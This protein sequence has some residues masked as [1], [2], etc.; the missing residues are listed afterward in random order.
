MAT[1]DMT[2]IQ[3]YFR[4]VDYPTHK[5][6]LLAQAQELGADDE[7]LELIDSMPDQEYQTPDEVSQAVEAA[8]AEG[9]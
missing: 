3:Q 1:L 6:D 5:Q 7:T 9:I 8:L 2:E 4:D